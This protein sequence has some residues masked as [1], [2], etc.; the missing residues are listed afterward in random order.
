MYDSTV[1]NSASP[2]TEP[3]ALDPEVQRLREG[4]PEAWEELIR[5]QG[6]RLLAVARRM[7]RSEPAAEDCLQT[8][9]LQAYRKV[10]DFQ[11]RSSVSTWLHRI[12]VNSALMTL[13]AA[14]RRAESSLD[15]LQPAFDENGHRFP[16]GR[17]L[18][19][20]HDLT[21]RKEFQVQ[22]RRAVDRLP[23]SYR[24]VL[25]LRDFEELPITEIAE[26]LEITP[27]AV[28]VR[29]HR[30]R[31]ALRTLLERPG[32]A[33]RDNGARRAA[34]KVE[35]LAMR[36]VPFM[37]TCQELEQFI[38]DYLEGSL[39]PRERRLFAVHLRFCA[40]CREYLAQYRAAMAAARSVCVEPPNLL[41]STPPELLRAVM[42]ALSKKKK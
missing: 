32:T 28:K 10:G 15:D 19:S 38:V 41:E 35:G 20:P 25:L 40:V 27:N 36:M 22:V 11:G 16:S 3:Q 31:A 4:R 23:D 30:A 5:A 14:K 1:E 8:A 13:R 9:L 24:I 37:I 17:P 29:L 33:P 6:G 42:G 26:L 34:R 18:A 7:L 2:P 39:P 21:E 12:V